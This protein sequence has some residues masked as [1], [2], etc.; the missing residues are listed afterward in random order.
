MSVF[1][2]NKR[3][4]STSELRKW[5][6]NVENIVSAPGSQVELSETQRRL[7]LLLSDGTLLV[8]V[9]QQNNPQILA[10]REIARRKGFYVTSIVPVTMDILR[11]LYEEAAR[12]GPEKTD[13]TLTPMQR[14]WVDLLLEAVN[15]SVSD[16]HI[17]INAFEADI[18]FRIRGEMTT[19]RQVAASYAHE[20][21]AAA[22]NMADASDSTY[23]LYDYQGARISTN[24]SPLPKGLQSVRLQLNPMGNGGRYLIGRLLY[25]EE[26]WSTEKKMTLE[27]TGM[28]PAHL[29]DMASMRLVP[30][31]INIV[32]GPTGSGKSTTLKMSLEELYR[33]RR[34]KI[35]ILTIED[36]PEYEIHGAAQLPVTNVDTDEERGA[37]YRKAIVAALRSDPDV[38]MPGEARDRE[39]INLVFTAAMTGHQVWTSLHA[40]SAMA[41]FDRLRDQGVESYKLTDP[42]LLTGLTAQRLI[43][44]LCSHCSQ[45]IDDEN[46]QEMCS[47]LPGFKQ[48]SEDFREGIRMA[49]YQGCEQ[50]SG[51]YSGRKVIV[52]T[53]CPDHAF[54]DFMYRGERDKA[55]Q[56]WQSHLD[57]IT[58]MEHAWLHMIAGKVDP[59]DVVDRLG[60]FKGLDI[61]RQTILI[62]MK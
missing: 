16:V 60:P 53:V 42:D 34:Q 59:R 55:L 4:A 20:L 33:E 24:S 48:V 41:I 27:S 46:Y 23:R 47:N 54:L 5:F 61:Q 38:I 21:A 10:V 40:N 6:S 15:L 51:G 13:S 43:K 44:Q 7:A 52:E 17:F 2:S 26:R 12:K 36:P 29:R 35:N 11:Q 30:E 32:S 50:C 57:G 18:K 37:A 56:H 31:G 14:E 8:D 22:Y 1:R 3:Q 28:H 45:I 62:H 25:A 58:M 49:D 9:E 19:I 39:V